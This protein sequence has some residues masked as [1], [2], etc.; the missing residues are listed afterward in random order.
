MKF[1]FTLAL[2]LSSTLASAEPV[3]H[4]VQHQLATDFIQTIVK[5]AS[6][7]SNVTHFKIFGLRCKVKKMGR[8]SFPVTTC[9]YNGAPNAVPGSFYTY[10]Q[11]KNAFH[12][13]S[14]L[15]N[16]GLK[17]S[18]LNSEDVRLGY[19]EKVEFNYGECNITTSTCQIQQH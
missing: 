1:A 14:A 7:Y 3:N 12:M 16:A 8:L 10:R 15:K 19:V 18:V 4:T 13:F 5:S 9:E 11:D 6:S 17:L 2:I